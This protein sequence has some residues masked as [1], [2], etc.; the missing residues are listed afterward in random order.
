MELLEWADASELPLLVLLNKAD[1]LG[2]NAQAKALKAAKRL[3]ETMP[4]V[5]V[6]LFSATSGLGNDTVVA[7]L[8]EHLEGGG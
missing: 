1:K 2:R 3:T 4:L 6:V 7:W 8:R 5:E